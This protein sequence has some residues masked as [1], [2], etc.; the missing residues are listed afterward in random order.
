MQRSWVEPNF[1]SLPDEFRRAIGGNQLVSRALFERGIN[2]LDSVRGFLFPDNYHPTSAQELPDLEKG[3]EFLLKA[4]NEN[5][6]I[7]IWG[8]F[9]V[10]GQTA[11]T[12][13]VSA[14][15]EMGGNVIFHI[16]VRATESHGMSIPALQ[17]F[18]QQKVELILTCDTGIS[19][20]EAIEFAQ[21]HGIPVIITDHHDLPEYLPE[22]LAIINP[23]KLPVNHPLSYLPGVGVAYKLVEYLFSL[24]GEGVKSENYLDLVALGIVADIA[25]LK[26]DTRYLLQRG[27]K[28]LRS[29]KRIGLQAILEMAEINQANLTEEHI[30]FFLAPRMN[31][32]GRLDDANRIVELLTTNDMNR[33]MILALEIEG[34]NAQRK[35]L[36]DQVYQAALAQIN[37]D[38]LLL[39]YPVLVLSHPMWPAGVIGIVASRLVEQFHRPTILFSAPPGK[40]AR[41]SARSIDT[42]NITSVIKANQDLLKSFGG[43]PMA[44]GLAIDQDLIPKFRKAISQTVQAL[45]VGI[46]QE[47]ILQIDGY[48]S[49]SELSLELV[50]DLERLAPF[51]AGNPPLVLATRNL[52]LSGYAVVGRSA[53]HLQLTIEDELGYS[54]RSIWWQGAGLTIPE[55]S[56]DLA[57]T[58]RASTYRGQK[59]VQIEWL[60]Y[61]LTKPLSN[62]VSTK[63]SPIEVIDFRKES[64][65]LSKLNQI[66]EKEQPLI[67]CEATL[68]KNFQLVDRYSVFPSEIL[69]I[70]T[71]P[72]GSNELQDVMTN[73]KPARVYLFGIDPNMD[74]PQ[75]FLKRLLGLLKFKIK[76][77]EGV[78]TL[79][80]LATATAQRLTAVNAGIEWLE[81]HGQIKIVSRD[82]EK[83]IVQQSANKNRI[84]S[85]S[86]AKLLH[87]SLAESAAFRRYYLKAD[88]DRLLIRE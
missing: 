61:R 40:E 47:R 62:I 84:D 79:S 49:L 73:V 8:D 72:P 25:L 33:A 28:A 54:Q 29:S 83:I 24:L 17:E 67:W 42:V 36:S 4:I 6:K 34:M 37:K 58:V 45:G 70:L 87:A 77:S 51:G 13:L 60:D 38:P 57:Y 30:A 5:K 65:P 86:S 46:Q 14:I 1:I 18:I 80:S 53:E 74:E 66:L 26:A 64:E 15:R 32:L 56:F 43:H 81:A 63:K 68:F 20:N 39:D 88:K 3:A 71:I 78:V 22:A 11:T 35:L 12:V 2:N 52:I 23:K 41:G 85:S 50:E 75:I 82:N 16:P 44:A 48:L 76:A 59:G 21:S 9:D 27:L 31:A 55:T 69:A 10:D 19:S 7:G